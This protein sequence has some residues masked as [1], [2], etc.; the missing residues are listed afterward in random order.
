MGTSITVD[1]ARLA[2]IR[3]G[4]GFFARGGTQG[5]LSTRYFTTGSVMCVGYNADR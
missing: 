5:P 1:G 3:H 4:T 2:Q